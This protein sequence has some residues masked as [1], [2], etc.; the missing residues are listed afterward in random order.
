VHVAI[1]VTY[2][3]SRPQTLHDSEI[4]VMEHIQVHSTFICRYTSC[5]WHGN[6]CKTWSCKHS[7]ADLPLQ[8]K[9]QA[10]PC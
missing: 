6:T 7:S 9:L 10:V 2:R 4:Q 5:L 8:D 1:H 3:R